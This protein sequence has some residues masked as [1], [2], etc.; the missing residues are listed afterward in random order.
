MPKAAEG[1]LYITRK[2]YERFPAHHFRDRAGYYY[3]V[4][5]DEDDPHGPVYVK[6]VRDHVTVDLLTAEEWENAILN[7]GLHETQRDTA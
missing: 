3:T 2:E 6:Q 1:K 7:H 5:M 4:Y